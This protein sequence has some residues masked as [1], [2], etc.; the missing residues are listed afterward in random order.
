MV[1]SMPYLQKDP[2]M[3][4]ALVIGGGLAGSL[5]TWRLLTE[6]YQ[7]LLVDAP[8]AGPHP[9][10]W[11]VAAGL[12]APVSGQRAT[13][14]PEAAACLQEAQALYRAIEAD[15]GAG[16]WRPLPLLRCF[17]A[18]AEA[19]RWRRRCDEAA[20]QPYLREVDPAGLSEAGALRPLAAA[21][22]VLG[23]GHLNINA[24]VPALHARLDALGALQRAKV[25]AWEIE[26]STASVRW[27]GLEA[28]QAVF[29]EGLGALGNTLFPAPAFQPTRGELLELS[30]PGLGAQRVL[31]G[32]H[33]LIPLGQDRYLCGATYDRQDLVSGASV[34][35][36]QDL[37]AGLAELLSVPFEV[38]G[39]RCGLRPNV[40]GHAPL[41]QRH[42]LEPRLWR[43]NGLGSK[44]AWS[45]P[46]LT[47][48]ALADLGS[49]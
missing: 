17:S 19:L 21:F 5:L 45:A 28:R 49:A 26:T 22:E 44:G 20:F 42:P 30:I 8:P 34:A 47:R 48:L 2:A 36:R 1:L 9:P 15:L 14:L 13:L 18:E 16:F 10:A 33:F 29:C 35:G 27:R 4:D 39:T 7:A 46:R 11:A 32:R 37:E 43:L 23:G 38:T 40:R 31:Y 41:W 12:A 3:L 6:G 25:E 24:L